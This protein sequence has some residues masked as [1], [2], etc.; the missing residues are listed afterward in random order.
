M[1]SAVRGISYGFLLLLV[2]GVVALEAQ[3]SDPQLGRW[4]LNLAKSTFNPGPPPKSQTRTFELTDKGVRYT[5]DGID[6]NGKP[7]HAEY[8]AKFD[9]KD[10]PLKGSGN[11]D[12]IALK[13]RDLYTL[14]V[15]QK[16]GGKVVITGTRTISRDGRVATVTNVGTDGQGRSINDVLVFDK[17]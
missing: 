11:A 17:Q 4:V 6:A 8:L 3:S 7:T 2:L 10:Y 1:S 12:S 5:S 9:G 13:R 16:K 14:E 15:T